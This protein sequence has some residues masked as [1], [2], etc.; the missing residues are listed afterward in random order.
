MASMK[1]VVNL[2]VG[3]QTT[4]VDTTTGPTSGVSEV[5]LAKIEKILSTTF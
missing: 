1:Y 5:S 2:F 3:F 4:G